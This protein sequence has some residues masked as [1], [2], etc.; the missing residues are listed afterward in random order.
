V[1]SRIENQQQKY[2]KKKQIQVPIVETEKRET[3]SQ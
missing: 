2:E 3:E 1:S